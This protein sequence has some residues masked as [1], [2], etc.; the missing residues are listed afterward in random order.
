MGILIDR[1]APPVAVRFGSE[2][3]DGLE[4]NAVLVKAKLSLGDTVQVEQDSYKLE[5]GTD[6]ATM[7]VPVS[8][9][10]QMVATL[11]TAVTGWEGP[12]FE[13]IRYRRTIWEDIDVVECEWWI[14][15]VHQRINALNKPRTEEPKVK[16][17][18]GIK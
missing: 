14:R 4:V 17:P 5:L 12:L 11:K 10:G 3:E 9:I 1:N 18:N 2:P 13:G 7:R 8:S 16:S 15:L 6:G